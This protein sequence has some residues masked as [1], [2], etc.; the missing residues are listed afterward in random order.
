M[1]SPA[2]AA[3][4]IVVSESADDVQIL[5]AV[6]ADWTLQPAVHTLAAMWQGLSSGTL[7]TQSRILF[8]SDSLAANGT[9]DAASLIRAVARMAEAGATVIVLSHGDTTSSI[10]EAAR[11]SLTPPAKGSIQDVS[12]EALRRDPA[13]LAS[14]L[15]GVVRVTSGPAPVGVRPAMPEL[16]PV[17]AP[18]VDAAAVVRD[19]LPEQADRAL[20]ARPRRPGQVTIT[21]TSSKGGSGKSTASI[22]LSAAIARASAEA[23]KPLSVCLID[24]DTRDGQVASM[25]GQF[26]PTALNVRIQPMW[27]EERIRRNLVPAPSLGIETLLAP[28][29]PR[30]A[31]TVGP[32]FYRTIVR[33]LQRMFDVVVMDTSV[34]YLDPLI[35]DVA[36]VEAD[37]VLFVTNLAATAVQ[38]M[39]R[40]LREITAPVDESGLGIP[41]EK[42]GIIVN[43][44]VA[45]VGMGR[46]Q[47]LAAGLGVPV[48]GVIPLATRDVL[49][50]TNL[51]R[52][53]ELLDH[54][55]VGPA[56]ADLAMA[57]LP[58]QAL[59]AWP[60][61]T[62]AE[63][64]PSASDE[65]PKDERRSLFRRSS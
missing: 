6:P 51:N 46:D 38:G 24:L 57:C 14:V 53:Q 37:E 27:D 47:V 52:M 12:A 10:A 26:M 49:S 28:I 41:R 2:D 36:L 45:D 31:Q 50:A 63:P 58:D 29:R 19:E 3:R 33:S 39:A 59:K 9:D 25:I 16:A 44:S 54:P 30:T 55:V 43:Q 56:Y 1:S 13:I 20:L 17:D 40:A 22:L 65:P 48:V 64:E 18:V 5:E 11:S 34:Q 23:G 21:V 35:A 15:P 62:P 60:I 7:D 42:L 61:D 32:D 4:V 8:F